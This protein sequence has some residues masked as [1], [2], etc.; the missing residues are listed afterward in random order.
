MNLHVWLIITDFGD[1]AVLLPCMALVAL[2]LLI[3]RQT[4]RLAAVWAGVVAVGG[5]VVAI[6]KILYMGWHVGIPAVDFTGLSGHTT[7]AFIVW[8][9]LFALAIGRGP[10]SQSIAVGAGFFFAALVGYSRLMV[11][12]HSAAE[13]VVGAALGLTLSAVFLLRYRERLRL[14]VAR[15]LLL[16]TIL[17]PLAVGYGHVAPTQSYFALIARALSGHQRVYTRADLH[18]PVERQG[19]IV[20]GGSA[21]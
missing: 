16:V 10:V 5:G 14:P 12:A 13:V 1:S 18:A 8:P 3:G 7:L 15:F 2:W 9:V 17:L 11:H 21:L 20:G 4:R 6:T 19:R